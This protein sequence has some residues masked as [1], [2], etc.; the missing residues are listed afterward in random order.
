MYITYIVIIQLHHYE[1]M[2]AGIRLT[3][4]YPSKSWHLFWASPV[5]PSEIYGERQ[6]VPEGDLYSS[7]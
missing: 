2:E 6:P 5:G 4:I 7:V 3:Y 1:N